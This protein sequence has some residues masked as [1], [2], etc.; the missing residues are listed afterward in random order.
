MAATHFLPSLCDACRH[1]IN[2]IQSKQHESRWV[3][4]CAVLRGNTSGY[5]ARTSLPV[6]CSQVGEEKRTKS[7]VHKFS[8]NLETTS[9][10]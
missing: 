2:K 9:K 3:L 7:E 10:F 1:Q 4:C 6:H 8:K 5:D